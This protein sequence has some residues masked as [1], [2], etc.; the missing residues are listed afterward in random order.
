MEPPDVAHTLEIGVTPLGLM[1][2]RH[3]RLDLRQGSSAD[4][5]LLRVSLA[6]PLAKTGPYYVW[7][8]LDPEPELF[9]LVVAHIFGRAGYDA[10]DSLGA[11]PLR[12]VA[13]VG[14]GHHPESC[15]AGHAD[16]WDVS[17]LRE[18]RRAHFLRAEGGFLE[19]L[20]DRVVPFAEASLGLGAFGPAQRALLGCSLSSL[21][22][23][24]T[25]FL[26]PATFGHYVLGSPSL[27]LAQGLF[28]VEEERAA[29]YV[30]AAR[31]CDTGLLLLAGEAEGTIRGGGNEIPL[32][33][34]RLAE[35]LRGRKLGVELRLVAGE[36]HGSLK[37]SLVSGG[38]GW[39]ERRLAHVPV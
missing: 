4:G 38:A 3:H 35:R 11:S 14:V 33:A 7:Y 24:R 12:R 1:R 25:I 36:D 22:A 8:V 26:R 21:L 2:T 32:Q 6:L 13:V 10:D 27:P 28:K 18:L 30:P 31:G 16:G 20:C 34:H 9:A 23:L 17:A 15:L 5:L 19:A 37:P 29:A 39:L